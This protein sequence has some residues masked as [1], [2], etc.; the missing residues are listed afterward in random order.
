MRKHPGRVRF[1]LDPR[2]PGR[3]DSG[4][5]VKPGGGSLRDQGGPAHAEEDSP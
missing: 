5:S 2:A 3:E 4:M 1:R